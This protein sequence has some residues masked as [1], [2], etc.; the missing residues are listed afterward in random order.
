MEIAKG[1]AKIFITV[2]EARSGKKV[3]Y[4]SEEAKKHVH[5]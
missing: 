3:E 2:I 1:R 4:E 5:G